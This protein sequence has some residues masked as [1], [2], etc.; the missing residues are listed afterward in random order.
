M[1]DKK[2]TPDNQSPNETEQLFALL[3]Q[4][5]TDK[6]KIKQLTK[7]KSRL[8]KTIKDLQ[9]RISANENT[10]YEP[11]EQEAPEPT[12]TTLKQLEIVFD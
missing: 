4:I 9:S 12:T 8:S 3:Q 6:G 1:I 11:Y 10:I 5:A 7:V 2:A